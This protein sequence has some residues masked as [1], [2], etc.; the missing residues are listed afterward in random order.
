MRPETLRTPRGTHG[1][2]ARLP[3]VV[4]DPS[5]SLKDAVSQDPRSPRA[6]NKTRL[7]PDR[8]LD[9][10]QVHGPKP[11]MSLFVQNVITQDLGR[12]LAAE[13]SGC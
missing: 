6:V 12:T 1:P 5:R 7:I 4:P 10:N 9:P 2:S 13:F 3:S 8:T 11:G